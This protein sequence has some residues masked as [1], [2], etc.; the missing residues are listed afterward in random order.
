MGIPLHRPKKYRPYMWNR[1]LQLPGHDGNGRQR[2][3][4]TR[5]RGF[6]GGTLLAGDGVA[7]RNVD[8]DVP[9]ENGFNNGNRMGKSLG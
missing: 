3:S 5:R 9:F 1:Y 6:I 8:Y 7:F 2:L 4:A